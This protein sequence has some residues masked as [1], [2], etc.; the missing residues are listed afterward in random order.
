MTCRSP[1]LA[2]L[3]LVTSVRVDAQ[4]MAARDDVDYQMRL[5]L[6]KQHEIGTRGWGMAGWWVLPDVTARP[7]RL[8]SLVLVGPL[9][10]TP[11]RWLELM[12]GTLFRNDRE[13]ETL[14][15]LRFA[16]R[17]IPGLMALGD[18]EYYFNDRRL[19]W[20]LAAERRLLTWRGGAL[21]GG[22]ESE[23]ITFPDRRRDLFGIGP[24][25]T[26]ALPAALG[27]TGAYQFRND[28]D[29]VRAYVLLTL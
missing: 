27:V 4:S 23:N 26:L 19:Y 14:V 6:H 2:C 1:F 20:L 22:V 21:R 11:Q 28:R 12:G 7:D 8:R 24:R 3:L 13:A 29:F 16:E 18:I 5:L 17:G 25:V 9:Y 15:N 10:R